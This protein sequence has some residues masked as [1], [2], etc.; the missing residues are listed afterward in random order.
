M[1]HQDTTSSIVRQHVPGSIDSVEGSQ[2]HFFEL[3]LANLR[4]INYHRI[5][6]R[7]S[8]RGSKLRIIDALSMSSNHSLRGTNC[9]LLPDPS[10]YVLSSRGACIHI[11]Y[12]YDHSNLFAP[13]LCISTPSNSKIHLWVVNRG[14]HDTGMPVWPAQRFYGLVN[15]PRKYFG[16]NDGPV[17]LHIRLGPRMIAAKK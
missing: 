5:A 17:M 9:L 1:T 13:D 7:T 10:R 3:V 16:N 15:S 12:M 6:T 14:N 2:H 8:S 4:R 11:M